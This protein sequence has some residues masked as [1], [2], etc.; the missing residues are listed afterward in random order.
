MYITD[1]TG[2]SYGELERAVYTALETYSNVHRGSGH[3]SM[4]STYL[5]EQARD[6]VVESLGLKKGKYI[7]IFCSGRAAE[8]LKTKLE[9]E[10][11][12]CLSGQD[13]GLPL[14]IRAMV[15]AKKALPSGIPFQTGGGTARLVSPGWI[16]WAK[17]PDRFE[18][19][20]PPIVNVIAFAKALQ[21]IKNSNKDA[22]RI[23][24]AEKRTA[25]EIL[26]NDELDKYSGKELL[27]QLKE[28]MI[29]KGKTV[30]TFEGDRPFINLD[31]S[32]STPTFAPIWNAARQTWHASS[33]TKK[34]IIRKV[35]SICADAL[36]APPDTYDIIFTSNSTESVNLA[37][38][39]FSRESKQETEPVVLSTLL[40]HSSNDLPW[41]M[42]QG[43]NVIRL[44]IDNEGFIDLNELETEVIG[45]QQKGSSRK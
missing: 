9:P 16:I 35:R 29:G 32:A 11:F 42:V 43:S 28:T 37:A 8:A 20:T 3:N 24:A 10:S 17:G 6:I 45:L 15:V 21:I 1:V 19:G 5:Y 4:V 7:V 13:I 41:R 36:G 44:S 26:Y 22:F 2:S 25:E 23:E 40:E 27:D 18:A 33:Q 14:G 34:E 31:N 30:P 39:S 12:H 38:E